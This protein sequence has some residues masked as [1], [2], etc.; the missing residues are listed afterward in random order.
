[1][2]NIKILQIVG[3]KN[4]GK[5]TLMSRFIESAQKAGKR[6]SAIKHHGHGGKPNLPPEQ[7]DSMRFLEKGAV[8]SLVCGDGLIQIHVQKQEENLEKLIDFSLIA[9]P[10][11]IFIEGFKGA[12]YPKVVLVRKPED[13]Q[14][15][16]KLSNIRLVIAH[17]D[18]ALANTRT[19]AAD[20]QAEIDHFFIEW[21]EGG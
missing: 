14:E 19:V 3:F 13:W 17:A 18:V 1:M 8:S 15:L 12:H 4:S 6:V 7:T 9:N 21:M 5:T 2:E 10:E 11:F 20:N 16:K